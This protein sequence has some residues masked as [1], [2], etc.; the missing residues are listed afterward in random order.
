MKL[1]LFLRFIGIAI[2][3]IGLGF[4]FWEI[5]E[6]LT[7]IENK[8]IDHRYQFESVLD[9]NLSC[10]TTKEF[11]LFELSGGT[12]EYDAYVIIS[13]DT[14]SVVN[15]VN[16]HFIVDIYTKEDFRARGLTFS[17]DSNISIIWL[18]LVPNDP[19]NMA[20]V[21]HELFHLTHNMMLWADIPLTDASDETYA[22]ELQHLT[23]QFYE[24]A[25]WSAY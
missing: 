12:F 18:P 1:L 19:E 11:Q 24:Q 16:E 4:Y 5:D 25:R 23:K 6:K 17:G 13:N 3:T 14:D 8:R 7:R 2:V 21:N 22:Y 15:F 9:S 10:I 20:I